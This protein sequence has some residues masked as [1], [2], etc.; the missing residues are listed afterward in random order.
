MLIRG[1]EEMESGS[2]SELQ[3]E[4]GGGLSGN[5]QDTADQQPP[6]KKRYHRHTARQIQEMEAYEPF[7]S[8]FSLFFFLISVSRSQ[9]IHLQARRNRIQTH[10]IT[11]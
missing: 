10:L 11:K 3:I 2:G 5:D 7:F 6:K 1:K 8:F 9:H 4:G